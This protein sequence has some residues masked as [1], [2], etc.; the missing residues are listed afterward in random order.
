M[1]IEAAKVDDCSINL[2]RLEIKQPHVE[3]VGSS[4]RSLVISYIFNVPNDIHTIFF[5]T[6]TASTSLN[7]QEEE[8][9]N[10][11]FFNMQTYCM[12]ILKDIRGNLMPKIIIKFS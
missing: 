8:R 7:T 6:L 12:M 3:L 9:T 5:I 2:V 11:N 1:I 4:L 10:I